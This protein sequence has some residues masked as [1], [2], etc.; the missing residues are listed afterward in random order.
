MA[1]ARS[2]AR[3][4]SPRARARARLVC[5]CGRPRS[6]FRPFGTAP[7]RPSAR[8]LTASLPRLSLSIP[9]SRSA[10]ARRFQTCL[11]ASD[12]GLTKKQIAL[13]L[14]EV[15]SNYDGVVQYAEFVPIAF[16][17]LSEMVSKQ[18]E[19]DQLPADE[20]A[21]MDYLQ[22]L[23]AEYDAEGTGRL[24]ISTLKQAFADG[25]IGLSKLQLRALLA[26]AKLD[27]KGELDYKE[28]AKQSAGMI[29]SILSVMTDS[30]A[31]ARVVAARAGSS[32]F[33]IMGLS[34]DAFPDAMRGAFAAIDPAG[35]GRAPMDALAELLR[36]SLGLDDRTVNTICNVAWEGGLDEAG[37]VDLNFVAMVSFDVLAQME[38]GF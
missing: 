27:A 4:A 14:D 15:D 13:L 20:A 6:C 17:L 2:T 16:G 11:K 36:G 38:T 12:L 10:P 29:A 19:Y 30:S 35:S 34:R 32:S 28:F 7:T 3:S 5:T 31:A 23:F 25:D 9:R 33:T 24:H 26:E 18:M 21:A 1:A 22:G 37:N 8:A